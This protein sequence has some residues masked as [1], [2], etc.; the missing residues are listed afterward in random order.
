MA[1]VC[2]QPQ[3]LRNAETAM[4]NMNRILNRAAQAVVGVYILLAVYFLIG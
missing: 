4:D 1:T 3:G 2:L